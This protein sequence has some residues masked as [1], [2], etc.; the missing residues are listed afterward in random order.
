MKPLIRKL[1][2][3]LAV[4]TS[5]LSTSPSFAEPFLG[6]IAWVPYNFAPRGWASC[7]GQL[8]PITQHN[9]LF[10]LLGTVY[11][12]DGRT[13]FALPDARGRVMIHEGQG[14]GLTNRRLGD[15]WGEEQVTLQTSQIPSHTHRQQASSGSPSSTSP[16]E[17]VLASPSRTQLYADDAD[18][19]M[20]AD[21]ISY[22]GGN[23]AHNNMQPYT[24]LHC[25]I[26]L[27]G[28]YPS[29]N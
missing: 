5:L 23:L 13:T 20:S 9:A 12:G 7:D 16:E 17:N 22:T 3:G 24:T 14:P 2:L 15:K 10:S 6:E 26:A 27:V 11:G 1:T 21:N 8:L 19:D 4:A 25:I 28:I 18:I 29:R